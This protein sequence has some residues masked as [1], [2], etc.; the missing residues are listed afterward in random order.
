LNPIIQKEFSRFFYPGN[1]RD[2][3]WANEGKSTG[4]LTGTRMFRVP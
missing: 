1:K 4:P 2:K 3:T